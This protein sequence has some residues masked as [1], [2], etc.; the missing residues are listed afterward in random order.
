MSEA[1][2]APRKMSKLATE[3]GGQE[4]IYSLVTYDPGGT[5]GWSVWAIR[6]EAMLDDRAKILKNILAWSCGEIWGDELDQVSEMLDLAER[7]EKAQLLHEDFILKRFSEARELLSPVRLTFGF[8][9]GLRER[10]DTRRIIEQSSSLALTTFT[11]ERLKE[12]GFYA[13]TKS[14]HERS[15][16]SHGLTWIRRKKKL[17]QTAIIAD[18]AMAER[19]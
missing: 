5:T 12:L 15:A 9:V 11:D 19:K 13:Q 8:K 18:M 10:G 16:I 14:D 2:E 6:M 1:F 4:D 3:L 7:W 17:I